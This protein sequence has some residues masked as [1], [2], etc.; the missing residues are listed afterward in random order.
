MLVVLNFIEKIIQ[1]LK[2]ANKEVIKCQKILKKL[3]G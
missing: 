2:Y 3:R 1:Y